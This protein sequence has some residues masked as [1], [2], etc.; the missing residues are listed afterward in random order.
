MSKKLNKAQK[1]AL[2]ESVKRFRGEL[3]E[4]AIAVAA[5]TRRSTRTVVAETAP[6]RQANPLTGDALWDQRGAIWGQ[7]LPGVP[8]FWRAG[9]VSAN[10]PAVPPVA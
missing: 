8:S 9:P 7:F 1:R 10:L 6:Q 2:K 3:K 4:T 5:E